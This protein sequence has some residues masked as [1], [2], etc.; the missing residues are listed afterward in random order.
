MANFYIDNQIGAWQID[1]DENAGRVS[2][3]LFLPAGV[4]PEIASISVVGD[5]QHELG[6]NDWDFANGFELR[7][8]TIPEGTFWQFT[9]GQPLPTNYYQYKYYVVFTDKS[10]RTVSD[11]CCRYSGTDKQNA[12]VVVGG[13]RPTANVVRP[14]PGGRKPLQDLIIYEL[15]IDDFTSEYRLARAPLDAVVD[16]L[17]ALVALGFNTILFMPWIAWKNRDF[18]WG[19]EPFQYFAVEYRYTTDL[20]NGAAQA[21]KISRLKNLISQCHDRGIHV[22]MDGVYN[23]VSVDFPYPQFYRNPGNCPFTAK[24]F[25]GAFPGLQDLDFYNSCTQE[26]IRDVCLYWIDTFGID[27]IR[28]DNSVNY[29]VAGDLQGLPDLLADIQNYLTQQD[30]QN[31]TLMLE[32]LALNAPSV[33]NLTAANSYWDNELYEQA[34]A[35]LWSGQV[36][37]QLVNALNNKRA[38]S[39]PGKLPTVYL[40]NHDHSHVAWQAGA[41]E[42]LGSMRWYRT[43]PYVIALYTSTAVPLIQNGQ[44]FGEDHWIPENDE[45]TGRRVVPRSLQWKYINN[46]IGGK[47]LPF[48]TKLASLR[49]QYEVLR[50]GAFNP[51][52]WEEWQTQFNSDGLGIDCTQQVMIYQRSGIDTSTNERQ[53]FIIVLNFSASDQPMSVRFPQNGIWTDLLSDFVGGASWQPQIQNNQ[54][55]FTVGSNW[56]H[57]FFKVQL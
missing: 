37:P 27:G 40:S 39:V 54:L 45:G 50:I 4:D 16:K 34:F 1:G 52:S 44:E 55:D 10:D 28:F 43:Q 12:A 2:F 56:G 19:Y 21:E 47:L 7:S 49:A 18:D 23:H 46:P 6:G 31:F 13:S 9:T 24:N 36:A 33:T 26:L 41:R 3:K 38:L 25:G 8:N 14:L 35:S 51:D 53:V 48:Y 17:D 11:P 32:H 29:Y 15:N 57:I 42:N 5:F 30:I 20:S 22:I